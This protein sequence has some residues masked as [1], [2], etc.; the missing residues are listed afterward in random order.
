V[1]S[2]VGPGVEPRSKMNLVQL[3]SKAVR[4]PLVAIGATVNAGLELSGPTNFGGWG[5]KCNTGIIRTKITGGN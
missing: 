4:K 2:P 3:H 1:S 5:G